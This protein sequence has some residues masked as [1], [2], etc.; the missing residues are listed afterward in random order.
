MKLR[1]LG[2]GTSFGVPVLGCHCETCAS[3]DPRDQRTRHGALIEWGATRLLIDTPPELRLQLLAG[4]VDRLDA[5]WFTH[6]HA[7]HL[8]GIDDLRAFT[9]IW[10][11]EF[12]VF[13]PPGSPDLF[14]RRFPYIFDPTVLAVE[15]TSKPQLALTELHA[16]RAVELGG[17]S[18]VPL[19]VPH[20]PLTVYGL[21]VGSLA[22]ITDAKM[23]PDEVMSAI[24]GVDTLVLNALWFGKPHPTHFNVEEAIETAR[25]VGARQ[26]FLTHITHRTAQA[27]FDARLPEGVFAAYDGLTID[28]PE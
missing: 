23:L 11:H 18:L 7:D 21:R 8:H 14:Y 4:N 1:F 2:T 3:D 10:K 6:S 22:Y 9:A 28:I 24:Q 27:E 17:R 20:G 25:E 5:V 15:G 16:S 26:T 13:V 12:P 19:A